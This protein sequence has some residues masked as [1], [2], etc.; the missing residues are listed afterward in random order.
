MMTAKNYW[1]AGAALLALTAYAQAAGTKTIDARTNSNPAPATAEKPVQLAQ[2]VPIQNPPPAANA[3]PAGN[4]NLE[5]RVR[6]LE[7]Q[8]QNMQDRASS[9]RTRLSTLEQSYNYAAWTFDNGRPT[10]ATGD[11][12]FT[13]SIRVRFQSDFAGFDQSSTHPAGFAGPSDLSS[14]MVI[15]RAYFG[16]E[17][18]VYNDFWYELRFNGGGSN[19]GLNPTCTASTATTISTPPGGTATST[20]SCSIGGI[21][22]GSEGD[23]LLNKAVITYTGIPNMHINVGIIEPDFNFEGSLSTAS[24]IFLEKPEIDDIA[25]DSFGGD[26]YRRGIEVVWGKTDALWPGDNITASFAFDGAKNGSAAGHGNGGDEQTN[27]LGRVTDRFWSDGISNLQIGASWAYV[28]YTGSTA[29]GGV[30]A[31]NFQDRPQIRVDGT[32]LISTG[33][34]AAKTG[35]MY[36]F[37]AA[38]NI[39]NFFLA[40]EYANFIADRQCGSLSASLVARCTSSTAVV[41]HPNV[42]G[43]Y[44]EGTWVLTGETRTYS[45]MSLANDVATFNMPVPSRPFSLSGGSWGAWELAARYSDTDLN[46]HAGQLAS[47]TQ[48]AGILGGEER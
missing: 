6:A 33:N 4:T 30:Q 3:Q 43:W 18:K 44:V 25:Q 19:G 1:M 23:P 31:F 47:T 32:R 36:A 11:G 5:G 24:L 37:E 29:G 40:G 42:S 14:G 8:L 15:R 17:G 22:S 2:N 12:R 41:D 45:P 46:W 39:E 9:D 38:G 16:V 27:F 21:Q 35:H 13:M 7:D 48:L 28:P 26:A 34:I 10:L 20:S